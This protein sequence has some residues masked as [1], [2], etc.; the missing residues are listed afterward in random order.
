MRA[1]KRPYRG[2]ARDTEHMPSP[3]RLDAV[4]RRRRTASILPVG[5]LCRFRKASVRSARG[6]FGAARP[7]TGRL[8][9]SR[10][11]R[12]R[13]CWP[14]GGSSRP[15]TP[16]SLF[17]MD[18]EKNRPPGGPA[19]GRLPVVGGA[20]PLRPA[21]VRPRNNRGPGDDPALKTG[22]P[23][24]GR[25]GFEGSPSAGSRPYERDPPYPSR[26]PPWPTASARHTGQ[27]W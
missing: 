10:C 22:P 14:A 3:G 12:G 13:P 27:K 20:G 1:R 11:R 23:F 2:F 16:T 19:C 21:A 7:R 26:T 6:I 25:T 17:G 9:R 15:R 24:P 5:L 8:R 18:R 4:Q